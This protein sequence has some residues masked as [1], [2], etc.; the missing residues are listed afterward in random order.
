MKRQPSRK[1][2][3]S[4]RKVLDAYTNEDFGRHL[5]DDEERRDRDARKMARQLSGGKPGG[6]E[7]PHAP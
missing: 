2:S 5:F 3:T 7:E 6:A 1:C 4:R